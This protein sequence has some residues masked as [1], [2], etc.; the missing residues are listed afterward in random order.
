MVVRLQ[1]KVRGLA[2]DCSLK[3]VRQLWLWHKSSTAAFVCSFWHYTY[4]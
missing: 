2:F 4:L 1:V 3:A